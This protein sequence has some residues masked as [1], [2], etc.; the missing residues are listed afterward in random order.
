MQIIEVLYRLYNGFSTSMHTYSP[1][2]KADWGQYM[3]L[4]NNLK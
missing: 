4:R 1:H 3:A 2:Y